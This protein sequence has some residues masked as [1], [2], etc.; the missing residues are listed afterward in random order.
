MQLQV[1]VHGE[2]NSG[3][4]FLSQVLTR[5]FN[6]S[7]YTDLGE[8]TPLNRFISTRAVIPRKYSAVI[9]E[10]VFDLRHYWKIDAHGGWKHAALNDRWLN[11][12][13]EPNQA[14]VICIVR[15][16]LAWAKSMHRMPY[17]TYTQTPAEFQAFIESPWRT[18]PREGMPRTVL[19]SPLQLW[20]LKVQSYV[21]FAAKHP[22]LHIIKYEDLVLDTERTVA[23]LS[24]WCPRN[25]Q[26][27]KLPE[28]NSR[29]FAKSDNTLTDY[30]ELTKAVSFETSPT[31]ERELFARY[32]DPALLERFD[33]T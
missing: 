11:K 31:I 26:E 3:T 28:E 23:A 20:Q 27:F 2:R 25:N 5:N 29:P 32:I 8:A 15:H 9:N 30:I 10:K 19:E 16:P 22:D 12:F 4:N 14:K 24:S 6:I 7:L 18:R 1:K 33:Y 13:A 21:D 17:H